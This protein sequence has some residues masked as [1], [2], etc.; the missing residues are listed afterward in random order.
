VGHPRAPGGC[1]NPI[2]SSIGPADREIKRNK[3]QREARTQRAR[4]RARGRRQGA[5]P[6]ARVATSRCAA[7]R[8]RACPRRRRRRAR[9]R[10]RLR[11][12][13]GAP[14]LRGPAG[15]LQAAL[16]ARARSSVLALPLPRAA[17]RAHADDHNHGDEHDQD[18]ELGRHETEAGVREENK[19]GG[20]GH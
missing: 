9:A 3:H 20:T 2:G 11:A 6:D 16:L 19:E 18:H 8:A 7:A 4:A 14:D 13:T 17:T 5:L 1:P 12:R 15:R 10:R